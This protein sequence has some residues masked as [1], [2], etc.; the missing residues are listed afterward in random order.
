LRGEVI[1]SYP[2]ED[3]NIVEFCKDLGTTLR[4]E[5]LDE[6]ENPTLG[7][8][9]FPLNPVLDKEVYFYQENQ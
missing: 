7:D 6:E 9:N 3:T 1:I 2:S 8:L 4:K 5:N